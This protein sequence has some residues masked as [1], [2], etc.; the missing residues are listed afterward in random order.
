MTQKLSEL[1]Q[2]VVNQFL[3]EKIIM[4]GVAFVLLL[5]GTIV[6]KFGD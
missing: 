1:K 6:A 2:G 3:L 4:L 5:A